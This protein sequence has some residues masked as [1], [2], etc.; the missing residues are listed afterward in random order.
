M[1]KKYLLFA[2]LLAIILLLQS[3]IIVSAAPPQDTPGNGPPTLE[4]IVFVHYP[5]EV[6]HGKPANTPG[7]KPDKPSKDKSV[8]LYSYGK[9][10]WPYDQA[11]GGITWYYNDLSEP[12]DFLG[13]VQASFNTWDSVSTA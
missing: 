8:D 9:V 6:T 3:I 11:D 4:R 5:K 10:H 13:A 2:S 1:K 7:V 12:G